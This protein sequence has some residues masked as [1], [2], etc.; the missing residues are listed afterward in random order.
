MPG[1]QVRDSG[2]PPARLSIAENAVHGIVLVRS[3]VVSITAKND[4]NK[5]EE[6]INLTGAYVQ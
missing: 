5:N 2:K 6:Q 3:K 4:R 1:S